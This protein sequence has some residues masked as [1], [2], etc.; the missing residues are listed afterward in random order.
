MSEKDHHVSEL[1]H[2][3]EKE[4][5][6]DQLPLHLHTALHLTKDFDCMAIGQDH[7]DEGVMLFK[8]HILKMD[9]FKLTIFKAKISLSALYT[10]YTW[11][12]LKGRIVFF[13]ISANQVSEARV[14][15]WVAALSKQ[16]QHSV[17]RAIHLKFN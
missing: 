3:L 5:L 13:A 11:S 14:H 8:L 1:F 16:F 7:I 2:F 12:H 17:A 6:P 15:L 9:T 10:S 4:N